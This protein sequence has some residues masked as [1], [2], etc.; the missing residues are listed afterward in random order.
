MFVL[1][2]SARHRLE[3]SPIW[4]FFGEELAGIAVIDYNGDVVVNDLS[5]PPMGYLPVTI[6][7]TIA[8]RRYV[9]PNEISRSLGVSETTV[10]RWVDS[11]RLAAHKTAGGHRRILVADVLSFINE[12]KLPFVDLSLLVKP[13]EKAAPLDLPSRRQRLFESLVTGDGDMARQLV[14]DAHNAGFAVQQIG[15]E[16][17]APVMWKVGHVWSEQTIDVY[18]E[19]L[20]TQLCLGALLSLKAKLEQSITPSATRP[21]ALGGGCEG[22]HY[23]LANLLVEM[24]FRDMGW[25]V[26]NIGPNTPFASYIRAIDELEPRLVWISCSHIPDMDRFVEGY[27]VLYRHAIKKGVMVSIGG[28]CFDEE[29]RRRIRFTHFGDRLDHLVDFARSLDAQS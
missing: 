18:Q 25:R 15:D 21:L 5:K 24:T 28:R 7:T 13:D 2:V 23:F 19:H 12:K 26:S 20:A 22:D 10:K 8:D 14:L 16:L 9:S 6:P 1:D 27:S 4:L 17:V 29:T 11:G 3:K